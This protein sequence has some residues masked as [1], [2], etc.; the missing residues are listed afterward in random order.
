[1]MVYT[2]HSDK[3]GF[4]YKLW[5]VRS[6]YPHGRPYY[7]AMWRYD[8]EDEAA[9]AA[10]R[11]IDEANDEPVGIGESALAYIEWVEEFQ[12]MNREMNEHRRKLEDIRAAC[13][14]NFQDEPRSTAR[15]R[16]VNRCIACKKV[17]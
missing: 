8:T 14:H 7:E 11:H 9:C 12:R 6:D 5:R 4:Y 13:P 1:M 3:R 10:D 15:E 2:I 17:E 16:P